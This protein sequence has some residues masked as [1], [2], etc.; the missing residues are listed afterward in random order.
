MLQQESQ[1]VISLSYFMLVQRVTVNSTFY[2]V[3]SVNMSHTFVNLSSVLMEIIYISFHKSIFNCNMIS[4][5]V[6]LI[7]VLRFFTIIY[8]ISLRDL[9][10]YC[11]LSPEFSCQY[12]SRG[13]LLV[14]FFITKQYFFIFFDLLLLLCFITSVFVIST[15]NSSF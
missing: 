7:S 11:E 9:E 1:F 3:N 15:L 8:N 4:E 12:Y 2:L 6:L 5:L 10:L 14:L 13:D